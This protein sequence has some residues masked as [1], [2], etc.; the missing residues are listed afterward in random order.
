MVDKVE[1]K[2]YYLGVWD[3][4]IDHWGGSRG[5]GL[6]KIS[7]SCCGTASSG[8]SI[9]SRPFSYTYPGLN[10]QKTMTNPQK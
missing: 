7:N 3:T 1:E 6:D 10:R 9:S 5:A 4:L 8:G 2:P